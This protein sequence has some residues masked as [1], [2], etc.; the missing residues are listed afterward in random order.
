MATLIGGYDTNTKTS[1]AALRKVTI[2]RKDT[3]DM[4]DINLQTVNGTILD[5]V[6][7]TMI[8]VEFSHHEVHEG[9]SFVVCDVQDIDTTTMKWQV[10][11]PASTKYA[12]MIFDIECTGEMLI[13]VTEGSDRTDGTALV[14]INRR[15]I[16]T[17]TSATVVVTRTPT[18]GATDGALTIFTKRV[19]ATGVG[20]KT[21]SGGGSRGV[22]E[23][24]LKPNTKYVMAVTTYAAV[25]VSFCIDWYEHIDVN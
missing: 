12:H 10:T 22:N 6:S 25:S 20:S 24:I 14:E 23:Y 21:I 11:T 2:T 4:L 5:G 16:G 8:A 15:R 3:K 19:G 18:G 9:S 13:L 1:Q 17:P 7:G